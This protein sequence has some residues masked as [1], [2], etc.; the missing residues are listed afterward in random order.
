VVKWPPHLKR[1]VLTAVV[2][3]TI[4]FAINQLNVVIDGHAKRQRASLGIIRANHRGAALRVP[5][6]QPTLTTA[7][8][9]GDPT[10]ALG[11]LA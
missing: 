1:T 10:T 9:L 5:T 6:I 3:G 7:S 4:L 8:F 11:V 2:V